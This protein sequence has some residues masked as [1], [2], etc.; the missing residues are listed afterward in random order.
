MP[1]AGIFNQL[2]TTAQA[3]HDLGYAVIP[4]K[5]KVAAVP[6]AAFQRRKPD[7]DLLR[8]WFSQPDITGIG[9]LTGWISGLVV[10]DFDTQAAYDAFRAQCGDLACTRTVRTRRGWHLYYHLPP[11]LNL[12]SQSLPG[13]DIQ[14]H[15]KY[16]VAP[17]SIVDGHVYTQEGR[18]SLKTLT[19]ADLAVLAAFTVDYTC[20]ITKPQIPPVLREIEAL[21][22]S[23]NTSTHL[24]TPVLTPSELVDMYRRLAQ[25]GGRNQALFSAAL[26]ARDQ[27][28]LPGKV[29][30][31]LTGI[32]VRQPAPGSH[33]WES[34]RSREREAAATLASV[35]SRPPRKWK[36]IRSE[37]PQLPNSVREALFARKQTFAV[38]TIEALRLK[39]IRPG[40]SFTRQEA[41]DLL[42]GIVGQWSILATFAADLLPP[43]AHPPAPAG[44][45]SSD[46]C[47]QQKKCAFVG[48]KKPHLISYDPSLTLHDPRR[49]RKTHVF[50]MPSNAEL[51][52]VLGVTDSGGDALTLDDLKTAPDTR[53]AAHRELIRRRPGT[54][55]RKWLADRLGVCLV[56][57]DTYNRD[58]PINVI[59]S[60]AREKIGW[61]NLNMVQ[62]D[63]IDP[64]VFLMDDAGRKYPALRVIAARLLKGKRTVYLLRQRPSFY[65]YGE[66]PQTQHPVYDEI[67]QP[68]PLIE[69]LPTSA[70]QASQA[71]E[72]IPVQQSLP[73]PELRPMPATKPPKPAP[74]LSRREL[75]RPLKNSLDERLA[76]DIH[77]L[78]R[79]S[80]LSIM[81][82]R[83]LVDTY[84]YTAAGK[85]LANLRA[86]VER[87]PDAVK[88]R[89]GLLITI[90]RGFWKQAHQHERTVQF[91]PVKPRMSK[92][93]RQG[94][95]QV[96]REGEMQS[97]H[98][99]TE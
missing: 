38:R 7:P 82:A 63:K 92:R 86:R 50:V 78:T 59:H 51:C 45:P 13:L 23:A 95:E 39:G 35:Y 49:G 18:Y 90:T 36:P 25:Q 26:Q 1:D 73:M 81:N 32:H 62:E 24:F 76:Q 54:Y 96:N 52:A 46:G 61:H 10:L 55:T 6:W 16:V 99:E 21:Q 12:A 44:L 37:A 30:Q 34:E 65:S 89:A 68:P 11:T 17:P 93:A 5:G 56:T 60:F 40:Q 77:D 66:I 27:G 19:Q 97:N 64:S 72:R 79:P 83:K 91:V 15:G 3:Y 67:G 22:E 4:L 28:Y 70:L 20:R 88:S 84:G 85:G 75:T 53:K 8:H 69:P 74:G 14:S 29:A 31:L 98:N 48:T 43:S 94:R 58:I 87:G 80:G 71:V 57:L 47:T 9:I 41:L 33:R 2:L 42:K